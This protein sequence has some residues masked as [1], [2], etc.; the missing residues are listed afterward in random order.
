LLSFLFEGEF[1]VDTGLDA[2][3]FGVVEIDGMGR[4]VGV[5]KMFFDEGADDGLDVGGL[6]GEAFEGRGE[7]GGGVAGHG[8]VVG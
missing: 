7:V 8:A 6:G 3:G 2:V 5:W 4:A 1:V